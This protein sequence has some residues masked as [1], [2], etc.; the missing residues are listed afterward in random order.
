MDGATRP[1]PD[2]FRGEARDKTPPGLN[3]RARSGPSPP[4]AGVQGRST[5]PAVPP[6]PAAGQ[7]WI[8]A[9]GAGGAWSGHDGALAAWTGGGWRFL[10]PF[11]G[12]SAWSVADAGVA[13]RTGGQWVVADRRPA[14]A[15]PSGGSVVDVEARA[16][17][18]AILDS[19]R[20]HGVISA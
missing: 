13:R 20:R 10:A 11:E 1:D 5:P 4:L 9:V 19:M 8:V 6:D 3:H 15:G 12:M 18:T 16:A 14:I 17:L 2:V 7:C